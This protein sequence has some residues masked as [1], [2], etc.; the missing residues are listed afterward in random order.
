[1]AHRVLNIYVV[2]KTMCPTGYYKS[3]SG[4]MVTLHLGT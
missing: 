2:K 3:A 4:L 1:M